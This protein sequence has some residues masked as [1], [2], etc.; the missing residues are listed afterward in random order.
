M[1]HGVMDTLLFKLLRRALS[2][3]MSHGLLEQTVVG[4]LSSERSGM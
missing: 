1:T 4:A 2:G 3:T